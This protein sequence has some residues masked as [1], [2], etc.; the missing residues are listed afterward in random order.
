MLS[1]IA[2]LAGSE[3]LVHYLTIADALIGMVAAIAAL[4]PTPDD[5][6]VAARLANLLGAMRR[7]LGR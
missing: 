4:T 7:L 6:G 5:D 2:N 1:M 3:D